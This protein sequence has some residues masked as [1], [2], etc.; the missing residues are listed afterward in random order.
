MRPDLLA[1]VRRLI[2][3]AVVD[4]HLSPED[5]REALAAIA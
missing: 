1:K 4:G 2:V 5:A 3:G